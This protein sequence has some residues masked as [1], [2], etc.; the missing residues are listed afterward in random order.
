[1]KYLNPF[2]NWIGHKNS[3]GFRINC[4]R[5][6]VVELS[7]AADLAAPKRQHS[8]IRTEFNASRMAL[9]DNINGVIGADCDPAWS[10]EPGIW[11][12]PLINDIAVG[13]QLLDSMPGSVC[14]V[15]VASPVDGDPVRCAQLSVADSFNSHRAEKGAGR[16]E[17]LDSSIIGV[18]YENVSI[19]I[20]GN[21]CS[22]VKLSFL[23]SSA[24]VKHVSRSLRQGAEVG[25]RCFRH[26][27]DYQA[28]VPAVR[29][30]FWKISGN[31]LFIWSL[32]ER[33]LPNSAIERDVADAILF[34]KTK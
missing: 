18:C 11:P 25:R 29:E 16:R 22:A 27:V 13:C 8:S 2:V 10:V 19:A 3:V 33:G 1:M 28:V 4:Y 23:T 9:V 26:L 5:G 7:V 30:D 31:D 12:L 21:S 17:F 34:E 15:D 6:V 20:N 32:N 14:H 24:S